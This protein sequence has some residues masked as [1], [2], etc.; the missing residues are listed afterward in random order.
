MKAPWT[1]PLSA[2]P[3]CDA[4]AVAA[5]AI[6]VYFAGDAPLVTFEGAG[7][8]KGE[9]LEPMLLDARAVAFG[10]SGGPCVAGHRLVSQTLWGSSSGRMANA[11]GYVS[12]ARGHLFEHDEQQQLFV[13]PMRCAAP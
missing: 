10:A 13:R 5:G 9:P 11:G 3:A 8:I 7:P 1:K 4:K 12:G 2:L 6:T